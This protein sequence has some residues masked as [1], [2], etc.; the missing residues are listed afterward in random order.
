MAIEHRIA[1]TRIARTGNGKIDVGRRE[2]QRLARGDGLPDSRH[3]RIKVNPVER[4]AEQA[5]SRTSKINRQYFAP[6]E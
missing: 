6:G 3:G 1:K 5:V 2:D 4:Q